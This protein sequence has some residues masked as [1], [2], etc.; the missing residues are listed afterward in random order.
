MLITHLK[1]HLGTNSASLEELKEGLWAG[2]GYKGGTRKNICI[3]DSSCGPDFIP[4]KGLQ[5]S[6]SSLLTLMERQI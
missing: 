3:Y 5:L 6:F 4:R 1:H 2:Q